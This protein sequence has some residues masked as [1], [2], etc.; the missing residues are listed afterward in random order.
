MPR[1][2]A[3]KAI[4]ESIK[5]WVI[6]IRKPLKEGRETMRLKFGRIGWADTKEQLKIYSVDCS[7]CQLY[8]DGVCEGCPLYDIEGECGI[9]NTP[10]NRFYINPTLEKANGMIKALIKA[11]KYEKEKK[12]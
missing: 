1:P 8:Y 9:R 5:H 2:E 10:Y 11:Y 12:P 7:L 4:R 3:L 6:D